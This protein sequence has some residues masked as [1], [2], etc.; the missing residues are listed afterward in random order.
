VVI[1]GAGPPRARAPW[2]TT[3]GGF[4]SRGLFPDLRRYL[5]NA[6]RP[7]VGT[8]IAAARCRQQRWGHRGGWWPQR[9]RPSNR[10]DRFNGGGDG[11]VDYNWERGPRLGP[12][13]HWLVRPSLVARA[14]PSSNPASFH[15]TSSPAPGRSLIS[16][17]GGVWTCRKSFVHRVCRASPAQW[18]TE[19]GR[20]PVA[21]GGKPGHY[22]AGFAWGRPWRAA[23]G[24]GD[25]TTGLHERPV[26]G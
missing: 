19:V 6:A 23:R 16:V 22:R 10:G 8:D 9:R 20:A 13:A 7:G 4:A 5:M 14:R 26:W 1:V 2:P 3:T 15:P 21:A 11:K 17:H 12:A 24:I 25:N 18:R